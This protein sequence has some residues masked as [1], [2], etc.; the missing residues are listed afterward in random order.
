MNYDEPDLFDEIQDELNTFRRE[1]R[2]KKLSQVQWDRLDY[3]YRK[4]PQIHKVYTDIQF[5][6]S[7]EHI[8]LRS[9]LNSFGYFPID[10][11][12]TMA[13]AYDLLILGVD[14]REN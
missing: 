4:T 9:I 1:T 10:R 2:Y 14:Y 8:A 13:I 6:P 7:G 12:E 5:F 11:E 3:Q